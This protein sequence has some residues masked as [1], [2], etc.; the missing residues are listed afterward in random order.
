M[1]AIPSSLY[2]NNSQRAPFMGNSLKGNGPALAA[3]Y[4]RFQMFPSLTSTTFGLSTSNAS[5][6]VPGI[7]GANG[8]FSGLQQTPSDALS[9]FRARNGPP[10]SEAKP[11]ISQ[12][13]VQQTLSGS[14]S[15]SMTSSTRNS[16]LSNS[17]IASSTRNSFLSDSSMTSSQA[18]L[19]SST[20][21]NSAKTVNAAGKVASGLATSFSPPLALATQASLAIADAITTGFTN[22]DQAQISQNYQKTI[23][24]H[25]VG[26]SLV[27]SSQRESEQVKANYGSAGSSIGAAFGPLGALAG[28]YIGK[29]AA[30]DVP[31]LQVD[32][33]SGPQSFDQ[34]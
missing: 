4:N 16:F 7:S 26:S 24:S 20:L 8:R 33:F 11:G 3:F 29:A 10:P 28:Y 30:P 17:S 14:R 2:F 9:S 21:L 1:N 23:Q 32:T 5:K 34:I 6:Q 18:S 22:S 19:K 13:H 12:S 31:I 15:P 27:A 25:K